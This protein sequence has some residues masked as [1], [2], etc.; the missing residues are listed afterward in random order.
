[1]DG[2]PSNRDYRGLKVRLGIIKTQQGDPAGSGEPPE[3]D[4]TRSVPT[5]QEK[6]D[7]ST[8]RI[9]LKRRFCLLTLSAFFYRGALKSRQYNVRARRKPIGF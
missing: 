1:M 5:N 8:G 3:V 9:T 4:D 7:E 2:T 6:F